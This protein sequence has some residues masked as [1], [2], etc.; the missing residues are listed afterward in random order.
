MIMATKILKNHQEDFLLKYRAAVKA[1]ITRNQLAEYLDM[2][3]KSLMRRI[4]ELKQEM[5]LSLPALNL[6]YNGVPFSNVEK[7]YLSVLHDMADKVKKT[8][9]IN[10]VDTKTKINI[11]KNKTYVITAAQN[12][13]PVNQSFLS[14]LKE[15]CKDRDAQLMVIPFRY[16]NPTSIWSMNDKDIDWWDTS[17]HEYRL[18]EDL[19]LGKHLRVMGTTKIQPTAVSPLSGFDT[20]S[21]LDSAIFGHPK[22]ELKSVPSLEKLPKLLTTTGAITIPNYTDS[23]AG[24]KGAMHHTTGAIV[25]EIDEDE[26]FHIRHVTANPNTGVF[27]DLNKKYTPKGV[28]DSPQIL[29]LYAGDSHSEVIDKDVKKALYTAKDSVSE[30]LKPEYQIF[31]DVLDFG[32]R[33]HHTIRDALGRFK[34]HYFEANDNVEQALQTVANFL[35]EVSKPFAKNIIVKANHDEHFDRWLKEADPAADPENA[36]FY[37]YMKYNQYKA[38]QNKEDFDTLEFWTKNP[39]EQ[40]GMQNDRTVFLRRNESFEVA[41]VEVSLHGDIGPNGARGSLRGL[42]KMGQKLIC[43]HSHS[44]GIIDHSYQVGTSTPLRLDYT[45]GPSSWLNT[46][47]IIYPD[48]AVTLINIING[49]W[50]L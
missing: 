20:I 34:K 48:G 27:Y 39:D 5:G 4:Q 36:K 31:G 6:D 8:E 32:V 33:S 2:K 24:H 25:L 40:P 50:K 46:S 47:A 42:S 29:A 44:P 3:P 17:I 19:K 45:K 13:T 14:S 18:Y 9:T 23:K 21:E 38:A 12:A 30:L 43:G 1:D 16:R 49:K 28:E 22:V 11:Q 7:E 26:I 41:G 15:F 37:Y 35:D 10:S